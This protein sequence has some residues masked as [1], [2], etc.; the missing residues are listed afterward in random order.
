LSGTP[1]VFVVQVTEQEIMDCQLIANRNGHIACT[2]GGECLAGLRQALAGGIV[3][4]DEVAVLDATAHALKFVGFQEHYFTGDLD[5]A[6]QVIPRAELK[7]RPALIRA[8][9]LKRFPASG[10]PLPADEFQ[11][12]VEATAQEIARE[13]GLQERKGR[14][15]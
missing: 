3:G 6:Y 13:L 12:F 4:Q 11:A 5:S 15:S 14:D 8:P 1:A 9:G 2:Q 10:Q 7:N